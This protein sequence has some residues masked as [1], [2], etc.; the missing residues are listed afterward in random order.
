MGGGESFITH[1]NQK[2]TIPLI[3]KGILQINK[4]RHSNRKEKHITDNLQKIIQ[5]SKNHLNRCGTPLIFSKLLIKTVTKYHFCP[6]YKISLQK[7]IISSVDEKAGNWTL[8]YISC[9][10]GK[11]SHFRKLFN[12]ASKGKKN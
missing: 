4:E 10:S 5:I 1:M 3:H 11:H 12:I 6:S 7:E 2:G 9:G 8:L